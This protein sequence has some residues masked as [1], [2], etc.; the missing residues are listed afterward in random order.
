[1]MR[2]IYG[3]ASRTIIWLDTLEAGDVEAIQLV[4]FDYKKCLEVH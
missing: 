3:A 1:M 2:D 4:E